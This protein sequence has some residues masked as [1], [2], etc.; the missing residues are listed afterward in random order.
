MKKI[1]L[2]ILLAALILITLNYLHIIKL[3]WQQKQNIQSSIIDSTFSIVPQSELPDSTK[4]VISK[5]V[6]T[7]AESTNIAESTNPEVVEIDSIFLPDSI[8]GIEIEK[9]PPTNNALG[10]VMRVIDGDTV[11]IFIA[12]YLYKVRYLLIETPETHDPFRG[13]EKF[14]KEAYEFNKSLVEGKIVRLEKDITEFDK[15]GRLLRYVY[16]DSIMVNLELLRNGLAEIYFI[17]P[18]VKHYSLFAEIETDAQKQKLGIWSMREVPADTL[19][20][21]SPKIENEYQKK[22]D[23]LTKSVNPQII[24]SQIFYDGIVPR[25]ESDEFVEISNIGLED[26]SLKGWKINAGNSKQNFEFPKKYILKAGEKCRIYTY[27]IHPESGGFSFQSKSAIWKN[28]G[29]IGYLLNDK[30]E[31]ISKWE[32]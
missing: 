32:Y 11:E 18:D 12:G 10:K 20:T 6:K 5:P 17:K 31:L 25:I 4:K 2:F 29:D 16:L 26:I 23:N 27:E 1:I 30:N 28:S 9:S 15:Y 14:G 3:P 22:M 19:K 7:K 13:E 8:S 24:I 21:T